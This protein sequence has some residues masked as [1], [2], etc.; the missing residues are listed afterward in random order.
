M[1]V[2]NRE[3]NIPDISDRDSWPNSLNW[4][5]KDLVLAAREAKAN[6]LVALGL[7][8]YT[9]I[10]GRE[11]LRFRNNDKENLYRDNQKCFELFAREYLGYGS[12]L[13]KHQDIFDSFRNGLCHEYYIK[14]RVSSGI[15]VYYAEDPDNQQKLLDSGVD[16]TKGIAISSDGKRRVFVIEPYL[17][18]FVIGVR[19]FAQQ[20]KESN[21]NLD[22]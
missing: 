11:V 18:D 4:M 15:F 19:K 14:S 7:F 8:C 22:S 1:E 3:I 16:L 9:E 12:I 2:P 6:Y 17:H 20:I 10:L 5:V 21:W 13:D